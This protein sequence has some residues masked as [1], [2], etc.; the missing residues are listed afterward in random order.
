MWYYNNQPFTEEMIGEAIAFVYQI[1]DIQNNMFYIGKKLFTKSKI[2]QVKKKKKKSRVSSDWQTYYGSNELLNEQ[3][4]QHGPD[5]FTRVILRLCKTKGEASYFETKYQIQA[6]CPF[7]PNY[8]N[9]WIQC[10]ISRS[11]VKHLQQEMQ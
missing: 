9:Q 6:N 4:K 10:K 3:V 8:Y 7:N 1:H 5:K 2:R 11:H